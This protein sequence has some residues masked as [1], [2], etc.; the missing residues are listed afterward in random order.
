MGAEYAKNVMPPFNWEALKEPEIVEGEIEN[1]TSPSPIGMIEL[2]PVFYVEEEYRNDEV[3]LE[4]EDETKLVEIKAKL[5][6]DDTGS[7]EDIFDDLESV[8]EEVIE[9]REAVFAKNLPKPRKFIEEDVEIADIK[10]ED[11]EQ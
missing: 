9:Y 1:K 2:K 3:D 8:E 11:G 6:A 5:P 7:H 4:G 10:L